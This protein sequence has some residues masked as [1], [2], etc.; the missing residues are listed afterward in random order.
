MLIIES[1]NQPTEK[2]LSDAH[3]HAERFCQKWEQFLHCMP[4]V[5]RDDPDALS[6]DMWAGELPPQQPLHDLIMAN[7]KSSTR[8]AAIQARLTVRFPDVDP[9]GYW[10]PLTEAEALAVAE[11]ATK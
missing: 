5:Y 9:I 7:L 4:L 10:A 2:Q 11:A 6:A 3:Q 1:T 8:F